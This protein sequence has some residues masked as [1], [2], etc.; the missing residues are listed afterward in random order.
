[1]LRQDFVS[2]SSS[3]SFFIY[4]PNNDS[5]LQFRSVIDRIIKMDAEINKVDKPYWHTWSERVR[6]PEDIEI[7]QW[8][9][10]YCG[11][12]S[13]ENINLYFDVVS[14]LSDLDKIE[15]YADCDAH[16]TTGKEIPE[17]VYNNKTS[18]T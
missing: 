4:L 18:R 15:K 10:I 2:N 11:E 12:D 5:V 7:N 16:Y 1:M 8:Y 13:E 14:E 9:H 17:S 6:K 3:C